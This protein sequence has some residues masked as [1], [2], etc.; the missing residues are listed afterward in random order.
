MIP[1]YVSI[2]NPSRAEV[3]LFEKMRDELNDN[4]VVLHSLGLLLHPKKPWSEIDFVLIGPHGV[5]C[6]EVK[7]GRV[8]RKEGIWNFIDRAGQMHA[9]TEGPFEQV[10]S[11]SAALYAYLR[12][13]RPSMVQLITGF[14]VAMPD[15]S[16]E[17]SG[18]DIDVALVYDESDTRKPFTKYIERLASHWAARL[19]KSGSNLLRP[20]DKSAVVALLR[21]DFELV[22]SLQ[23]KIELANKQLVQLT[24]EQYRVLDGLSENHRVVIRGGAGTGKTLLAAEETRRLS[25][26]GKN[27]LLCCFNKKLAEFLAVNLRECGHAVVRHFHGL[28]A[29]YIREA[30]LMGQLPDAQEADL[31]RVF[32]PQ[33]CVDAMIKLNRL[34]EFDVLIIDEA[35]DILL[36]TFLDVLDGLVKGGLKTGS[37]KIFLD[38]KQDVYGGLASKVLCK[39]LESAPAQY[40]LTVNCRNTIPIAIGTSLLSGIDSDETLHVDGPEIQPYW[41]SEP[42]QERRLVSNCIGRIL[43][44][45]VKPECITILSRRQLR[46]SCIAHGLI[47]VNAPV[48]DLGNSSSLSVPDTIRFSTVSLFKG[49]ESDVVILL[50]CD[51]LSSDDGR[52]NLYVATSRA[53]TLLAV[54]LDQSVRSRYDANALAYGK[55]LSV[56]SQAALRSQVIRGTND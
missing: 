11:A 7:G 15:I 20:I 17:I 13:E 47:G 36:D 9:K 12:R 41:Y 31:F 40:K 43:S 53:R 1:S 29:D 24:E 30:G 5:F 10:G 6:L 34:G 16:F 45:G 39:I 4:W 18:P 32:Y 38:P 33:L 21:G 28:M 50:D 8:S 49:L 22:A 14:G 56:S 27:I 3:R 19:G 55:R 48:C 54:F 37:W 42:R 2:K 51:D 25:Q 35:Q 26:G 23:L 52:S 46:N 44:Q